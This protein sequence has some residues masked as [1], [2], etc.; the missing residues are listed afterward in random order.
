MCGVSTGVRIGIRKSVIIIMG[1]IHNS[2]RIILYIK[3][4]HSCLLLNPIPLSEPGKPHKTISHKNIEFFK[5][6]K[7]NIK[8]IK[9]KSKSSAFLV[10]STLL[11]GQVH[12]NE[13]NNPKSNPAQKNL[14]SMKSTNNNILLGGKRNNNLSSLIFKFQDMTFPSNN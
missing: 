4:Q 8:S 2:E 3:R 10:H 7:V 13:S 5:V 6:K 11:V 1:K 12:L 9:I 14:L